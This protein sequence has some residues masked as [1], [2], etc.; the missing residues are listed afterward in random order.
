[1][2]HDL[3]PNSNLDDPDYHNHPMPGEPRTEAGKRLLEFSTKG[4][5]WPKTPLDSI[6]AIEAEAADADFIRDTY[7]N[8]VAQGRREAAA[9]NP[10]WLALRDAAR[11]LLAATLEK[12]AVVAASGQ[13][14]A[15]AQQDVRTILDRIAK[16]GTPT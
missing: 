14:I 5:Q 16:E 8:G 4:Y 10:E 3:F 7:L 13:R 12:P 11:E 9:I 2:G 1:M 15:D 6:L